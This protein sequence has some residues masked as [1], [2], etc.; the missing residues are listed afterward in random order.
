MS[1]AMRWSAAAA[2]AK[3][4]VPISALANVRHNDAVWE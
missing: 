4:G 3:K 2:A 1:E